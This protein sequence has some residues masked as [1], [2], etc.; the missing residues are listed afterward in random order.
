MVYS[1][2]MRDGL[3]LALMEAK[4]NGIKLPSVGKEYAKD[5]RQHPSLEYHLNG[6]IDTC[7]VSSVG[8]QL[9]SNTG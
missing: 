3:A 6:I 8:E 4:H 5:F 7:G 9:V 1:L 2:G